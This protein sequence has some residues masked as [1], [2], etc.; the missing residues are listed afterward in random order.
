MF[1][2][3]S[4][5]FRPRERERFLSVH[6]NSI[7][8][9]EVDLFRA[10]SASDDDL[11][12]SMPPLETDGIARGR[13]AADTMASESHDSRL[14][15]EQRYEVESTLAGLGLEDEQVGVPIGLQ[16]RFV[17][18]RL[19]GRGNMG[20]VFLADDVELQ[21]SVA[22]KVVARRLEHERLGLRLRREARA[23]AALDHPN[24]VKIFDLGNDGNELFIAME[25]VA[26]ENLRSW[27][28]GRSRDEVLD[29]YSQAGQGLAAAHARGLVHR[30]FKPDNVLVDH[31]GGRARVRVGDFGLVGDDADEGVKTE[32]MV[33]QEPHTSSRALLGTIPYMAPEQLRR[34]RADA[35]SD[36]HQFCV[37]LWEALVSQR[38]FGSGGRPLEGDTSVPTRPP[39]IP[40]WVY[41]VLRRGLAFAREDRYPRMD[42]LLSALER[43]RRAQRAWAVAAGVGLVASMAGVAWL[44]QP[45]P[46]QDAAEPMGGIWT[47]GARDDIQA[48]FASRDAATGERMAEYIVGGIDRAVARWSEESQ[49]VCMARRR[50]ELPELHI[51]R[52]ESCLDQWAGQIEQRIERLLAADEAWMTLAFELVAP[53]ELVGDSCEIPPM[54]IDPSVARSIEQAEQAELVRDHEQALLLATEAVSHARERSKPCPGGDPDGPL[55]SSELAAALFR[56]G[57]VQ[58]DH[59]Q[60]KA[61]LA[62]LAEAHLHAN[63]CDDEHRDAEIRVHS[64]KLLATAFQDVDAAKVALEEAQVAFRRV[65][66]PAVGLRRYD[67]RMA[68]GIVAGHARDYEAARRHAEEGRVAL[69]DSDEPILH[70]K[71]MNNIGVAFQKEGRY[72]EAAEAYARAVSLVGGA[73][74]EQHPQ[75]RFYAAR[76]ALHLGLAALKVGDHAEMLRQLER[77]VELGEP[78][79]VIDALTALAQG[80]FG[81]EEYEDAATTA[82]A[83]LA[84]LDA[85][86]NLAPVTVARTQTTAGQIL[87]WDAH[88]KAIAVLEQA[89]SRWIDLGVDES[90]AS[91][92][93]TLARALLAAERREEALRR[94]EH[95]QTL[96]VDPEGPMPAEI[97]ALAE[98][99]TGTPTPPAAP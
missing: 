71:L 89:C 34:E 82:I 26:G 60:S 79:D 24:V 38:P 7:M 11:L 45:K 33:T 98:A 35:R 2:G 10:A 14:T 68:A 62:T 74:G 20:S 65:G 54:P 95:L 3:S 96:E 37:A 75:T 29:A 66:E 87:A 57:H 13:G 44:M 69:G 9:E 59:E 91:C 27:Q 97:E 93:V 31:E 4:S 53:L 77:V 94:L 30:D 18:R 84:F 40:R 73:L 99:L 16:D 22:I 61:A 17:L 12:A 6:D 56:L 92:E 67:E 42:A 50:A 55:R 49:E 41:R 80:Q 39:Q 28:K 1:A 52:R 81:A 64:A 21:R 83:L 70:A 32:P 72:R 51:E 48:K 63:A 23:L 76:E 25:H 86:P 46:C 36:Q 88:P 43:S 90:T 47:P 85:H 5:R 8:I 58:G 78:S 19:I 15:I